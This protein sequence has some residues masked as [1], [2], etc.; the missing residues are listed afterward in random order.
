VGVITL[1]T[2][3]KLKGRTYGEILSFILKHGSK[4]TMSHRDIAKETGYSASTV[5]RALSTLQEANVIRVDKSTNTT[6]PDTIVYVGPKQIKRGLTEI[7][8]SVISI[9]NEILGTITS[10]STK[11]VYKETDMISTIDPDKVLLYRHLPL[12]EADIIIIKR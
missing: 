12:Q 5:S 9:I 3:N 7:L 8:Y 6:L 10:R 11:I 2:D 1:V 4:V